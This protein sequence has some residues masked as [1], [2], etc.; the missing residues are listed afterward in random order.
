MCEC[1]VGVD[2]VSVCCGMCICRCLWA[3]AWGLCVSGTHARGVAARVLARQVQTTRAQVYIWVWGGYF[4]GLGGPC[5]LV[6]R[7]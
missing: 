3:A 6:G 4:C 2:G 5:A 7:C 1:D